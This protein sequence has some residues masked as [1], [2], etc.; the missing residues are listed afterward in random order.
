MSSARHWN[1]GLTGE[2]KSG[3]ERYI[4]SINGWMM[5][6]HHL[7]PDTAWRWVS[8]HKEWR[9]DFQHWKPLPTSVRWVSTSNDRQN[10]CWRMWVPHGKFI[11]QWVPET[12]EAATW[13]LTRVKKW[14]SRQISNEGCQPLQDNNAVQVKTQERCKVGTHQT[15]WQYSILWGHFNDEFLFWVLKHR[16]L[17][18]PLNLCMQN[19]KVKSTN[20]LYERATNS[21]STNLVVIPLNRIAWATYL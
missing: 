6:L 13:K 12:M 17:P 10:S 3:G 18:N 21:V 20:I 8:N 15:Y 16:N 2:V 5:K 7:L 19:K 1:G 14:D 11:Q 4:Y 9:W